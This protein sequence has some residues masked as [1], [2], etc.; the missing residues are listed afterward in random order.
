MRRLRPVAITG[1]GCLC[2]A[3]L[4]LPACIDFLFQGKRN[5]APPSRLAIA[6]SPPFPVF[7]VPDPFSTRPFSIATAGCAT[8]NWR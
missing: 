6:A 8:A 4:D 1:M 5:P 2:A 3:G 7:E